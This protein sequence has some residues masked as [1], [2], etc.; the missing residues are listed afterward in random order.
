[1]SAVQTAVISTAV[2]AIVTVVVGTLVQW[3][4]RIAASL[5][6]RVVPDHLPLTD[7]GGYTATRIG[8]SVD[9]VRVLVCCAPNRSRRRREVN[10][11]LAVRLVRAAF[12]RWVGEQ[13][14]Y[15]SPRLGVRFAAPHGEQYGYAWAHASGRVDLCH[16]I[17]TAVTETGHV[18]ISVLDILG[19][20]AAVDSAVHR[21]E[22]DSTFGR[23]LFCLPRRFDWAIAVSSTISTTNFGAISWHQL[24]FPGAVPARAGTDQLAFEPA[25]GFARDALR[26]WSLHRNRAELYSEF[27]RDFL[28]VNGFHNVAEPI[29]NAISAADGASP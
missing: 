26:N 20:L 6:R 9:Q 2:S 29:R 11:D 22:Y 23:R 25:E 19:V 18:T 8:S 27:L 21:P 14:V 12:G 13:P 15:S 24:D 4:G 5:R 7:G 17:P 10:P 16:A 3:G 28:Y 1:M